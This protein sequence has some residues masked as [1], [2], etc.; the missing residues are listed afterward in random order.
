MRRFAHPPRCLHRVKTVVCLNTRNTMTLAKNDSSAISTHVSSVKA[1]D[2]R[3]I[4]ITALP[5][6][7]TRSVGM[8]ASRY[9]YES[10][11]GGQRVFRANIFLGFQLIPFSLVAKQIPLHRAIPAEYGN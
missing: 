5:V 4:G 8:N 6:G 7:K 11:G 1:K 10:I 3:P 9:C 2:K